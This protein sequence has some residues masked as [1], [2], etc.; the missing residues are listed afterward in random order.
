[1]TLL[2]NL[3]NAEYDWQG[4]HITEEQYDELFP[5]ILIH[6][7]EQHTPETRQQLMLSWNFDNAHT[8]LEWV[9]NQP[10]TDKGTIFFLYWH[11]QPGFQKRFTDRHEC[12]ANAEWY[13][14]SFDLLSRI[15][16]QVAVGFYTNQLY[17]FDPSHD[18]Y[19]D[20]YDWTAELEPNTMKRDIPPEMFAA[21]QGKILKAEA[22]DEG[23][24]AELYPV[25]D[26]L[27]DLL[28]D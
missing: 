27:Y 22:W 23:V 17:A 26:R 25:M 11:M 21:L 15:E 8:V 19:Q 9:A 14:P 2:S 24:P 20:G 6:Y 3:L 4:Q 1:M 12:A 18:A 28:E 16:A 7:L 5:A 13:L 10:D